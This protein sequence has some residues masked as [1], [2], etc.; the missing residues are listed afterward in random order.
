[1]TAF[2]YVIP[3]VSVVVGVAIADIAGSLHLLLQNRGR[4]T[5]DWLALAT[6]FLALLLLLLSWWSF[7]N[8]DYGETVLFTSLV[9][10][11]GVCAVL[12]TL[13][14]LAAASLP[15]SVPEEGLDLS[16]FY[17]SNAGYFWTLAAIAMVLIAGMGT[18]RRVLAGGGV[19]DQAWV[20]VIVSTVVFV[21]LARTKRRWV[22]ATVVGLL[23]AVL[24][25][26]GL[27]TR[28]LGAV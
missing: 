9:G 10:F 2:E 7:Y 18:A 21:V 23:G 13:Y 20:P 19:G 5:W 1:M 14:L 24:L 4:I 11:A 12:I 3:L 25:L 17:L 28:V 16:E 26:V 8:L 15:S 27:S 6:A 22:H